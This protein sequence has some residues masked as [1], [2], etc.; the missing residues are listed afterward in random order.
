[1]ASAIEMDRAGWLVMVV[2]I[3]LLV[4]IGTINT[5]LMSV[6][7]RTREFGVIRALG[8]GPGG[9]RK[10][11]LAEG[12]VLGAVA[13]VIGE[14]LAVAATTYMVEHGIDYSGM[15]GEGIEFEGVLMD[16]V[17]HAG[18]NWGSMLW[19]G[20]TML[21]LA[22]LASLYPAHRALGIRPADAMRRY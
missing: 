20:V 1:M 19:M 22:V 18:W 16:P 9:I 2:I 6:M 11:I 5:L 8:V 4:G 21:G 3:Y 7:E 13:V 15:M 10:M 14:L 12:L 17:I